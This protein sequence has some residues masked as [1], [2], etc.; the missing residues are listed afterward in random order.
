MIADGRICT[1]CKEYKLAENFRLNSKLKCGLTSWCRACESRLTQAY[2]KRNY[3]TNLA[4]KRKNYRTEMSSKAWERRKATVSEET[5][6]RDR[7]NIKRWQQAHR[8]ENRARYA[9]H[10][11]K[12]NAAKRNATPTWADR[13]KIEEYYF[14][15]DFLG[16]VTG[17]WHNVD[18]IVPVQSDLVCGL[19]VEHNLQVLT[20]TDNVSKGNRWWPDMPE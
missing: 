14:A 5:K 2:N 8:V 20:K 7:E 3:E 13:Q 12:R 18:H 4:N 9:A 19:H 15:A 1:K 10:A 16:M 6:Q 17:I 11:A